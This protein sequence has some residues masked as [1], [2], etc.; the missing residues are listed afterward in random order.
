MVENNDRDLSK[1]SILFIKT[2]AIVLMLI[3]HLWQMPAYIL[4]ENKKYA[5]IVAGHNIGELFG[6]FGK[7]CVA[8][9]AFTTGY[10]IYLNQRKYESYKYTI[11]KLFAFL[12]NYWVVCIF[13]ILV[14][15]IFDEPLPNFKTFILNL[16]GFQLDF[17]K[18]FCVGFAWYV[19]FYIFLLIGV[20][21]FIKAFRNNSYIALA[22]YLFVIVI[23][24][25]FGNILNN[26]VCS[27]AIITYIDYSLAAVAGWLTCHY[28]L[29]NKLNKITER[30]CSVGRIIGA[31]F[32]IGF[33]FVIKIESMSI[34]RNH[35]DFFFAATYIYLI[36][37][38]GQTI[39]SLIKSDKVKNVLYKCVSVIGSNSTNIWYLHA[40]FFTPKN[41][42][43]WIAFFPHYG[44]LIIVWTIIVLMP[45]SHLITKVQN[46]VSI[47]VRK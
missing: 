41:T 33:L 9:F 24:F 29:Y 37:M 22:L 43:Q 40:L 42:L 27:P 36:I 19:H 30:L 28:R 34:L 3:H 10:L 8:I 26:P 25:S 4:D 21:A 18:V 31:L 7:I 47:V 11:K 6:G 14:G 38:I 20:P 1:F 46:A 13:F 23:L 35:V 17:S 12:L 2:N 44:V 16:F 15:L 5:V 32:L 45:L 39:H